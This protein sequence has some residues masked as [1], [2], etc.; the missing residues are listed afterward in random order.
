M[1]NG[2]ASSVLADAL[3]RFRGR[4]TSQVMPHNY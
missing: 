2:L 3:G 4:V 1:L